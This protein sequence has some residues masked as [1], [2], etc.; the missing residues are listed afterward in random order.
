MPYATAQ[1]AITLYGTDLVTVVCD[2][3]RDGVLDTDSFEQALIAGAD[4]ID[5]HF[6]GRVPGWPWEVP[7]RNLVKI[8]VD[9]AI[10]ICASS[11]R[12]T[13]TDHMKELNTEALTYLKAVAHGK[14][15]LTL[16]GATQGAVP[17]QVA[18]AS[19]SLQN[20]ALLTCGSRKLTRSGMGSI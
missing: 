11:G 17:N 3:D 12:D 10:Y 19:S 6:A 5:G 15:R 20:T 7:P 18:S 8:N 4:M 2:R 16:E 13:L 1:D 9:L 14:L